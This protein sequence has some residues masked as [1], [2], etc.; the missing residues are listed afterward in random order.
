MKRTKRQRLKRDPMNQTAGKVK[1]W[2]KKHG[3]LLEHYH[4]TDSNKTLHKRKR[5]FLM[6]WAPG[7]FHPNPRVRAMDIRNGR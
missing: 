2:A 1:A 6:G 4:F 3:A 7:K 5:P